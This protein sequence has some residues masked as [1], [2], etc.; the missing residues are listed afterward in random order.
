[1]E[2][3]GAP[4][5]GRL[6]E[7]ATLEAALVAAWILRGA[8]ERLATA[9]AAQVESSLEAWLEKAARATQVRLGRGAQ[10]EKAVRRQASRIGWA[11]GR[12]RPS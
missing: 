3:V 10:R 6:L 9:L 7:V 12:P 11:L 5:R 2:Q 4:L 1:M 8:G